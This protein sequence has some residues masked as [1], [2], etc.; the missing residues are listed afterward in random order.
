MCHGRADDDGG[1]Q[2][3]TSA[4]CLGRCLGR[5]VEV[6]DMGPIINPAS[7]V[8]REDSFYHIDLGKSCTKP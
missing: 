4:N 8:P 7:R 5:G 2:E 6:L 3:E 1:N